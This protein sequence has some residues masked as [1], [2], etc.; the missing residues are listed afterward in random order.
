MVKILLVEDDM[1]TAADISMQLTQLGYE[2]SGITP[3]GEDA[4]RSIESTRPDLV[5][6]DVHLKGQLDGVETAQRIAERHGIPLIF[7]TANADSATFD[8]AKAVKPYAFISK[9]FQATDLE[10]AIELALQRIA[11]ESGSH[12][13]TTPIL[14]DSPEG[15]YLLDDRI[16]VRYQDKM[17]KVFLHEVLFAEAER[18][19][20]KIHTD[21]KEYLLSVPLGTLEEKLPKANFLRVHRSFVV[22]LAKIDALSDQQELLSFGKKNVPVS[23]SFRDEL[24]KRLRLI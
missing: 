22:N 4:L 10:H 6:M 16:F 23:R 21:D 12:A 17:V 9:P 7:L 11:E 2:V 13:A 1:I 8:R 24:L 14:Q 5:L 3:R 18:S 19:Y 20:C 15:P